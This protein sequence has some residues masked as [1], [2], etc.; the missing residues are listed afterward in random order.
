MYIEAANATTYKFDTMAND[1]Q[2]K[3]VRR[4]LYDRCKSGEIS[5]DER[6]EMLLNARRKFFR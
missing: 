1:D 6:D 5:V 4:V 3:Q 2:F